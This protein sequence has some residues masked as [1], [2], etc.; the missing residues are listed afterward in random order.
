MISTEEK[1]YAGTILMKKDIEDWGEPKKVS[2]LYLIIKRIFDIAFSLFA[3]ILFSPIILVT[4]I[5]IFLYDFGSPIYMQD[6]VGKNGK[7]I[8]IFKFRSMKKNADDLAK[9]LTLEQLEEYHREF[10]LENDPR[11][12][13]IGKFIRRTSIDE[14]PQFLNILFGQLSL[15]GPRP[16]VEKELLKYGDTLD[17]F[18]S[19]KPGLTGYWQAYARN[20]AQ[21]EDC[22]RQ[23]MEL[24]YIFKRSVGFDL[25]IIFKTFGRLFKGG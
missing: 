7:H 15:V 18:L 5:C 14:L 13:S 21:Y 8:K 24:T 22:A 19:A 11:I 6:R 1:A 25:K 3:L 17:I 2:V 20:D 4:A 9:H 23:K 10:K 12:T 16:I